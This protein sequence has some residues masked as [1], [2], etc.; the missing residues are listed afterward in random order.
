VRENSKKSRQEISTKGNAGVFSLSGGGF[1]YGDRRSNS[2]SSGP[3][4][5]PSPPPPSH[6]DFSHMVPLECLPIYCIIYIFRGPPP[7]HAELKTRVK[8]CLCKLNCKN[9]YSR[10]SPYVGHKEVLYVL[11]SIYNVYIIHLSSE[12]ILENPRFGKNQQ[13]CYTFSYSSRMQLQV[14]L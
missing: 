14:A 8:Q 1:T 11:L 10:N 13:K 9:N 12:K 2:Y 7:G 5:P 3:S 6:P 4:P